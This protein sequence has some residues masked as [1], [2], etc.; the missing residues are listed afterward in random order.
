LTALEEK[1]IELE[2]KLKEEKKQ[3]LAHHLK[4]T[5]EDNKQKIIEKKEQL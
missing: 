4:K 1:Q 5:I 2:K 3:V